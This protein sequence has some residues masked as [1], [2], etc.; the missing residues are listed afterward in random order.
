MAPVKVANIMNMIHLF[1]PAEKPSF[2]PANENIKKVDNLVI[3]INKELSKKL[4]II[5]DNQNAGMTGKK[6]TFE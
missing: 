2:L 1:D 4:K 3:N 6:Q 5:V